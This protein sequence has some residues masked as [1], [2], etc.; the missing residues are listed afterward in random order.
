MKRNKAEHFLYNRWSN[1]IK[2]CYKKS[3][4]SFADYGGREIKVCDEWKNDF[5]SF[6]EW[7]L[8]NGFESS[9][10]IDRINNDGNYE[11]TNCR[12]TN[13]EV[14]ARNTRRL[15]STNSSGFR[16]VR[17]VKR[18]NG[19]RYR[20]TIYIDNKNIHLGICSTAINGAKVYDKYVKDNN[21]EHTTNFD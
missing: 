13:K 6:C 18:K 19:I 17:A 7:A 20:V 5:W 15:R 12:W 21:L 8:A 11:P 16:G 3:C 10:S 2:R 9:L 1:M 14:Q 4:K